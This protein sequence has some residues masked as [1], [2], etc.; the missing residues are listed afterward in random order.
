MQCSARKFVASQVYYGLRI[1]HPYWS[2]EH[3]TDAVLAECDLLIHKLD[4]R[5]RRGNKAESPS[6]RRRLPKK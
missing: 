1:A 2:A 4:S 3:I 5:S 6:S